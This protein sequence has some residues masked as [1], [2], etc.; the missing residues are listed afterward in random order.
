MFYFILYC[1]GIVAAAAIF[2]Y[3]N[4]RFGWYTKQD[5]ESYNSE[6]V[7]LIVFGIIFWPFGMFILLF[8]LLRELIVDYLP[9]EEPPRH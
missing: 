9:D 4:K 2:T 6:D 3:C 7:T 5:Y 1:V 8:Y